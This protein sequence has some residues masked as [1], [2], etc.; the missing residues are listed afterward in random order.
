MEKEN[1][2]VIMVNN[3][4]FR[5]KDIEELSDYVNTLQNAYAQSEFECSLF[6]KKYLEKLEENEKLKMQIKDMELKNN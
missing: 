1:E 3:V 2:A 4:E 5:K 6:K